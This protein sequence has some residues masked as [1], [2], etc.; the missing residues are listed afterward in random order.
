[1][2]LLPLACQPDAGHAMLAG[3]HTQAIVCLIG[4]ISTRLGKLVQ[5][6]KQSTI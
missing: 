2:V 4:S 5:N 3:S 1:M 6:Q